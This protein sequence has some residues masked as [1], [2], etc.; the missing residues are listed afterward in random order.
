MPSP[1]KPDHPHYTQNRG[2]TLPE[3]LRTELG[4]TGVY[5]GTRE[6]GTKENPLPT[7]PY[8]DVLTDQTKPIK[9]YLFQWD[10]IQECHPACGIYD[11]ECTF[12]KTKPNGDP[13]Q[14][15]VMKNF[16]KAVDIVVLR[17]Y[18]NIAETTF[19]RFGIHVVPLYKVY[20]K[21]L[22]AELGVRRPT[23]NSTQGTPKIH[24]IYKEIRETA[25]LLDSMWKS[26]N[27]AAPPLP[28]LQTGGAEDNLIPLD[29]GDYYAKVAGDQ[30]LTRKGMDKMKRLVKRGRK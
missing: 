22:I 11:S 17:N 18:P 12:P 7:E 1:K 8:D 9:T 6:R 30:G 10:A 3:K 25:R 2:G 23:F 20:C 27:M 16:L 15:Q 28:G 24:P 21:L 19:F 26:L 5:K 4:R 14:C 29:E 13:I